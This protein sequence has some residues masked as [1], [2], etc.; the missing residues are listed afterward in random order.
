MALVSCPECSKSVSDITLTM[1]FIMIVAIGFSFISCAK[2]TSKDYPIKPVL[3]TEVQVKDEFWQSRMET[4]R[5][6]T[7]PFAFKK[8]EETGRIDN[9]AKAGGLMPG[10]FEGR[11]YN[12]SDV[13]KIMEGAAYSLT[14]HPDPELEKVM[15]DLIVKIAAAQE[16]DGYLFTTRTIEP[17]NPAPGSGEKRWSNLASSHELYNVGHMYEAAVAYYLATGKRNFLDVALK[18][19][20]LIARE[21]GPGKRQDFPGHQEIEIGLVKLFRLTGDEKY[22]SLAKF[23]LDV[24]GPGK[25]GKKFAD[26]SDFS[27]YNQ[28]WYYQAHMP[29][30]E[31]TEAVGHAVRATYMYSGMA[32]VAALTGDKDYIKAIDQIWENVVSKKLYVTGGIGSRHEGEAFGEDYELPNAT[33]YNETC[34]A[35]GNVF[36]NY[37]L[38]LLHGDAKYIDVLE[39]TLYNG[40]I[41]G[42]SLSGDLFFYPNPLESNGKYTFNQGESTRKPWFDCACCPVNLVRFLP[43]LPGYVYAHKKDALYV[44]L[45]VAGQGSVDLG[46]NLVEVTQVTNYPWNGSV[47]ISID[48]EK[49]KDFSVYV[50]IPGWVRNKPLPSDLYYILN[51]QENQVG[52]S[53]NSTEVD[54]D[55]EKGFVRI[56]R[57]WQK[58]DTIELDLPM[59]VQRVVAH[60]MV[61]DNQGKVALQRGPLVYCFEGVD[62]GERVIGRVLHDEMEFSTE[63]H[64]DLLGGICVIN[65]N[66]LD[67][68]APITAVPYYAWSHRGIGE[69]AVWLPRK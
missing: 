3:F 11:R 32:D 17:D 54:M 18:N 41:S 52:L 69:M 31:Q 15:D 25:F 60:D 26:D 4:N 30:V 2:K 68:S 50:R 7:I 56:R 57:K 40:L 5:R 66:V 19:A 49:E 14:I 9:F 1:C 47:K 58:G 24:R 10:A 43:S 53:V 36:W 8:S 33:A 12:D 44:N 29:V 23:F 16:E 22:L 45:F 42:L 37:R 20:D 48:P 55:I 64:P 65:E 6:V 62:N 38:F 59:T 67:G 63:L 46:E 28:D 51:P 21:F 34:A 39:R 13:F 27:I 35:I 61:V